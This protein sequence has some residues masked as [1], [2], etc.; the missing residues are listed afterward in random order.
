MVAVGQISNRAKGFFAIVAVHRVQHHV[1]TGQAAFHFQYFLG[2]DPQLARHGGNL[3]GAERVAVGVEIGRSVLALEA[4]A[5]GAQI[6]KQLALG[7]GRGDLDHAPV[8]QDVFVDFG[9]DPMQRVAHQAHALVRVKALDRLHQAHIAFLDQVA[10]GQAVANVLARH[11]DHQAQVREHQL[12]RCFQVVVVAELAGK[13]LLF[14]QRE[15]G[16]AVGR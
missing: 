11:R 14:F 4:L 5:H 9:L 13:A 15:H 10:V 8:F 1:A 7:L 3:R 16:Q 6:E 12:S 2:L